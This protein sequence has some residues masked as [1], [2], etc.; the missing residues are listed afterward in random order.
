MAPWNAPKDI[1]EGPFGREQNEKPTNAQLIA[2]A[3]RPSQEIPTVTDAV[4]ISEPAEP[5]AAQIY[6][7]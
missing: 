5:K 3:P 2:T 4:V 1:P 7:K 6:E